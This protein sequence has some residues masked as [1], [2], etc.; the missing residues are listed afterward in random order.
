VMYEL[1]RCGSRMRRTIMPL[2][3]AALISREASMS[4]EGDIP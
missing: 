3:P 2:Y 4:R 1:T